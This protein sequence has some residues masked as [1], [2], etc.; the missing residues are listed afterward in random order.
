MSHTVSKHSVKQLHVT[1]AGTVSHAQAEALCKPRMW[2]RRVSGRA[3]APLQ[4]RL[5]Y[6]RSRRAMLNSRSF[7]PNAWMHAQMASVSARR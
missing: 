2:H 6:R 5:L 3:R 1:A 7:R 4:A